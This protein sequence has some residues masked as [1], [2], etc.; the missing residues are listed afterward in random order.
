MLKDMHAI[1]NAT[2]KGFIH[3]KL[4]KYITA[5]QSKSKMKILSLFPIYNIYL[6]S[7]QFTS[8]SRSSCTKSL[9]NWTMRIIM[10]PKST[11][12]LY[13]RTLLLYAA[14]AAVAKKI[15]K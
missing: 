10:F 14:N 5:D 12:H 15:Y 13:T 6:N 2:K 7:Y 9:I 3:R 1:P 11:M 4:R 8:L